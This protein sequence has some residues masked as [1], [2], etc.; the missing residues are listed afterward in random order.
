MT[1]RWLQLPF[2]DERKNV[3]LFTVFFFFVCCVCFFSCF[4]LLLFWL[5]LYM[6]MEVQF[7]QINFLFGQSLDAIPPPS[8][9]ISLTLPHSLHHTP[10]KTCNPPH[11]PPKT[12]PPQK[13]QYPKPVKNKNTQGEVGLTDKLVKPCPPPPPTKKK[14]GTQG[15]QVKTNFK[16]MEKNGKKR[17]W[18]KEEEEIAQL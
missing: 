6:N 15:T 7:R 17:Q 11:P 1:T 18:M 9:N 8:P 2:Y 12:H 13:H 4:F 10:K 16:D 14:K 3:G 5:L